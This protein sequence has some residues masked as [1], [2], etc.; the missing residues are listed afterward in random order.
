MAESVVERGLFQ[1]NQSEM[2]FIK[3]ASY[4]AE[5]GNVMCSFWEMSFFIKT[6]V[7]QVM[8]TS[9]VYSIQED[10]R[11]WGQC[12]GCNICLLSSHSW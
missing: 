4:N 12:H 6:G 1:G 9:P 7:C 10:K 11:R 8:K 3:A 5:K 2:Y